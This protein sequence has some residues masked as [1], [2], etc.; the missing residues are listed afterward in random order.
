MCFVIARVLLFL[1]ERTKY[2]ML[3]LSILMSDF[4][5]FEKLSMKGTFVY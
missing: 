5:L 1:C 4:I 3:L 2:I